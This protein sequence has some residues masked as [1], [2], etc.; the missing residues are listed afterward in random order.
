MRGLRDVANRYEEE[1]KYAGDERDCELHSPEGLI[2]IFVEH[3][4][5]INAVDVGEEHSERERDQHAQNN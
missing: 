1:L 3:C 2:L 5:A 4:S